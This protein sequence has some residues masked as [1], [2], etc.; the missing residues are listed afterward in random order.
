MSARRFAACQHVARLRQAT[1][2]HFSKSSRSLA[3]SIVPDCRW[4]RFV[5]RGRARSETGE[6]DLLTSEAAGRSVLTSLRSRRAEML[7]PAKPNSEEVEQNAEYGEGGDGED[8]SGEAGDFTAGDNGEKD[9]D[10]V[11]LEGRALD[12]G[13]QEVAF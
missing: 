7:L 1:C 2:R 4:K 13:G 3:R 6:A 5:V 9:E 8:Y 10:G 11:H 12:A